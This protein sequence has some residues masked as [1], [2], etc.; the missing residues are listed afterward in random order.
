MLLG[1]LKL[2]VIQK[3][4]LYMGTSPNKRMLSEW[5]SAAPQTRKCERYASGSFHAASQL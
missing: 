2:I 5:F 4:S 1:A 3:V